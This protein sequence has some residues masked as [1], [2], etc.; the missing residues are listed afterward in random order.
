MF[1]SRRYVNRNTDAIGLCNA[2]SIGAG[3]I[4]IS[5]GKRAGESRL[6]ATAIRNWLSGG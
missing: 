6:E 1:L 2:A 3:T 4:Q 5:D